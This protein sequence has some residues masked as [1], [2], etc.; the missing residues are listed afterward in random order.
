[1]YFAIIGDIVSS[2]QMRNKERYDLQYQIDSVLSEINKNYNEHIASDFTI[3]LGDECQGLLKNADC[4]LEMLDIIRYELDPIEI[5]F[6]I[7][8]GEVFTDIQKKSSTKADG[9]AFWHARYAVKQMQ[10]NKS[11]NRP[12]IVFEAE[13][14]AK[15]WMNMINE[16]LKLCDHIENKWTDKQKLLIRES[17]LRFGYDTDVPQ[18]ELAKILEISIPAVN[19]HMK[20]TGYYSYLKLRKSICTAVQ[21]E[22]GE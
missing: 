9:P 15:G 21:N 20:R 6:G 22:W 12:K 2:K 13:E 17:T 10:E 3:T 16:S 7:G 11:Y 4:L 18:K 19:V 14:D 5:R 8:I 1:M